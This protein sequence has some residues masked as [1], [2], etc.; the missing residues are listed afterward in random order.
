MSIEIIKVISNFLRDS[1]LLPDGKNHSSIHTN[2]H[3]HS[4]TL[5][6]QKKSC[7]CLLFAFYTYHVILAAS[8]I[9]LV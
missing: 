5:S 7:F 9:V 1:Y 4:L 6:Y 8:F 3:T 2:T